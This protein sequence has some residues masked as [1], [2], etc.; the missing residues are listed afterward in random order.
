MSRCASACGKIILSGEYAVVFGFPGIAIPAPLR[1]TATFME[2]P[3]LHD[4]IVDWDTDAEWTAYVQEIINCCISIGSV[5]AGTL[6]IKNSIPLGKGM[7][8]STALVI[9]ITKCLLGEECKNEAQRIENA[10]N[11][12]GS[13]IDFAVIWNEKPILFRKGSD[14]ETI[15]LPDNFL[16]NTMLLD[17][18]A[19]DQQTPELVAWISDRY[20]KDMN[21]KGAIETI[22]ECTEKI[23]ATSKKISYDSLQRI[24][25]AHHNAQ[26]SLG[27]VTEEAKNMIKKIEQ[28]GGS[29]KVVG[30]GGRTGGSGMVL[31]VGIDASKVP[32]GYP[33]I[34]L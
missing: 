10:L 27:V 28:E 11:P 1:V 13:G 14:S 30:A 3:H 19:P 12:G 20:T 34:R 32:S 9:A 29:A 22:G 4:I 23:I 2:N 8:S 17:S 25:R 31:A 5:H 7:G 15:E 6:R 21:V 24:I 26:E 18:G 33:L 16:S